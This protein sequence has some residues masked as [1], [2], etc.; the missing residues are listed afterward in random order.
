MRQQFSNV[1]N[2]VLACLASAS[3]AKTA[4]A[5]R[6]GWRHAVGAWS[7]AQKVLEPQD[8]IVLAIEAKRVERAL[9]SRFPGWRNDGDD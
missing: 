8:V 2:H 3:D 4:S 1:R 6:D 9:D 7:T 5:A